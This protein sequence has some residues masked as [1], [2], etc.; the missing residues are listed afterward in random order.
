MHKTCITISHA[1]KYEQISHAECYP[2]LDVRLLVVLSYCT[3]TWLKGYSH[4]VWWS[5]MYVHL[6]MHKPPSVYFKQPKKLIVNKPNKCENVEATWQP[7][8]EVIPPRRNKR[9]HC[10]I[11]MY[12]VYKLLR[13]ITA[14]MLKCLNGQEWGGY[15]VCSFQHMHNRLTRIMYLMIQY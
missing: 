6:F 9:G 5:F 11:H 8:I 3:W 14:N 12:H 4:V 1:I 7:F 10:D 2:T 15:Q 13:C